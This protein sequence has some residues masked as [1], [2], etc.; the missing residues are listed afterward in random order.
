LS[1]GRAEK[2][3]KLCATLTG[4]ASEWAAARFGISVRIVEM[5]KK[6]Q[7]GQPKLI[8]EID[9]GRVTVSEAYSTLASSGAEPAKGTKGSKGSTVGTVMP[10]EPAFANDVRGSRD[11]SL[12]DRFQ[13]PRW[14]FD[15]LNNDY[16]FRL[17]ACAEKEVAKCA[18]FFRPKQDALRQGWAKF[19]IVFCNPPYNWHQ[20]ER[21]VVKGFDEAQMGATVVML[22]PYF[23]SYSW[24]RYVVIP[25]AE[26]RQIQGLVIYPGYGNQK[27]KCAGNRGG[28][29]FD[30]VVA[31]F[32][33]G[34]RGFNG[35]YVDK[36]GSEPPAPP[37]SLARR[38]WNAR[39]LFDEN[40]V[41]RKAS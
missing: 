22:L 18:D 40:S 36:A 8:A 28:R 31:V 7:D 32:R 9:A 11:S 23:K 5:A 37:K 4:K 33:K 41:T 2:G 24:F 27:G 35:A 12:D 25:F 30:S 1:K 17:D 15:V 16:A 39:P 26:I 19:G 3:A 14:L 29:P 13:T 6:V 21:W 38:F 20:L 34:Q 10:E